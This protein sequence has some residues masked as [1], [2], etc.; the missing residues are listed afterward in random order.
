MLF[1]DSPLSHLMEDLSKPESPPTTPE[2]EEQ[3]ALSAP[4]S[5]EELNEQQ[6]EGVRS[7]Q[8]AMAVRELRHSVARW[9]RVRQLRSPEHRSGREPSWWSEAGY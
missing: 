8:A 6:A 2:E 7:V 9:R 1:S 5:P 4:S 3:H